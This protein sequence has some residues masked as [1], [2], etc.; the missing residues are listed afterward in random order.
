MRAPRV[1][2]VATG[3][4]VARLREDVAGPGEDRWLAPEIHKAYELVADG[5]VVAAAE[6]VVGELE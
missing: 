5:S 4:V 2:S 6:A 1:P 3:A